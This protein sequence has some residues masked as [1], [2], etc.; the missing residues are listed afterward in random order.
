MRWGGDIEMGGKI[1]AEERGFSRFG[2]RDEGYVW[3]GRMG[4]ESST[5]NEI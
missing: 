2:V 4:T 3:K 5:S 1:K